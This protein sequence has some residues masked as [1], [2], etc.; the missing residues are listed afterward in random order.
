MFASEK[1]NIRVYLC[2]GAMGGQVVIQEYRPEINMSEMTGVIFEMATEKNYWREVEI[3][4]KEIE[5]GGYVT[6]RNRGGSR[7]IGKWLSLLWIAMYSYG[8]HNEDRPQ[9]VNG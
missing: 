5:S 1:Y 7:L 2:F 6:E 8:V 9:S 4:E 3:I